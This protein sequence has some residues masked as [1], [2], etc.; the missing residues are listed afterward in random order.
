MRHNRDM[1]EHHAPLS[2]SESAAAWSEVDQYFADALITEDAALSAARRSGTQTT[3]PHAEVAPN[4]AALLALIAQMTGAR[5][6]LEFGTLA[7]YSTI[8][9]ARSVGPAGRVITLE[10][11][12]QNAAIARANFERAGLQNRIEVI[13][14]PADESGQRLIEEDTEPFDLVFIDADKPSNPQYLAIA[15]EL[16]R[17]GAVIVID[18][19]V[20]DGA[21]VNAESTDPRVRGVREVTSDIA[22]HPD[23]DGTAIQTVGLKGWD[24]MIIARRK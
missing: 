18:N 1:S 13:V 11:E 10:L 9:L 7:G 5:R 21:V 3:M 12:A 6:V 15:L 17:P 24:G 2:R 4:Q 19:V 14:G 16:T 22:S 20:R 23:L 8:Y